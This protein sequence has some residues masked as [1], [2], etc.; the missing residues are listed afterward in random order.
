V[1]FKLIIKSIL[2]CI[3]IIAIASYATYLKTGQFWIPS[4]DLPDLKMPKVISSPK[5]NSLPKLSE[6]ENSQKTYKWLDKGKWHYGEAPPKGVDAELIS[7]NAN[8]NQKI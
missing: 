2:I 5:M 7:S 4:F 1:V 8:K 3:I 6:M